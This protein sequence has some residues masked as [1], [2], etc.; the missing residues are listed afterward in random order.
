MKLSD[1]LERASSL[2]GSGLIVAAAVLLAYIVSSFVGFGLAALLQLALGW[3]NA[4]TESA[5]WVLS[6]ALLPLPLGAFIRSA[7]RGG[8]TNGVAKAD[9][10]RSPL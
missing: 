3:S 10:G 4:Q 6:L 5:F 1:R 2:Y 8:V 9:L 7:N